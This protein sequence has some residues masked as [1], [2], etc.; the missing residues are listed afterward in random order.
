M[1]WQRDIELLTPLFNRGAYQDTAELRP[2]SIRGMARWWFRALGG[3]A[4]EEKQAFGGMNRFGEQLQGCTIASHLVF[5]VSHVQI[6]RAEPK[7]LTLPHKSGGQASPQ[8]AFAPG[9]RFRLSVVGRLQPLAPDLRTKVANAL[10]TWLLLG[11]L[12]LRANRSGGNL[13]PMG[14]GVPSSPAG[15]GERLRTL[16]CRWPV[17]LAGREVGVTLS[18]LRAAATDTV[19]GA[20]GV[21]GYAKGRDRLASALKFKIVRLEGQLRLLMTAPEQGVLDEARRALAGHRC[22]PETWK[23][24]DG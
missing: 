9:G 23:P 6:E 10:D 21:F 11:A 24:L 8:A 7:P 3:S 16:G 2:T 19:N 4:D 22:K 15:L 14:E 5:R 17:M 1:N 13:W 12:G 20:A 18:D